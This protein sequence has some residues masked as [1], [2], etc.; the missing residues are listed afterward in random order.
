MLGGQRRDAPILEGLL[1]RA[2]IV[3]GAADH[4]LRFALVPGAV[5]HLFQTVVD[6]I[7]FEFVL[8]LDR[9]G[10]QAEH[11]HFLEH[12]GDTAGGAEIA[13]AL[14]ED[15]AH[16]GH[17]AGGIVGCGFDQQGD[18]MRGVAF[19]DDLLIVGRFLARG[20]A[21]SRIRLVLGHV[22][23]ARILQ[24]PAQR[25]IR[26]RIG[27]ARVHCNSNILGNARELLC[28][29]VPTRKHRVLS[30]FEYTSHG[31][32]GSNTASNR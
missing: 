21:N 28:H 14:H 8:I 20:T 5:A 32:H 7:Q 15:I 25:R 16:A 30:D 27:A 31:A 4:Q 10:V 13:G 6:Q 22:D 23:G 19:V 9:G 12:E 1:Q 18:S 17:G 24:H 26:R 2:E 3:E 29:A 11:A